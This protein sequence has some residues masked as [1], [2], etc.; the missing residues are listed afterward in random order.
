MPPPCHSVKDVDFD[1]CFLFFIMVSAAGYGRILD[2][3]TPKSNQ[4]KQTMAAN[5]K[6]NKRM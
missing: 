4:H 6:A 1:S 3:D 5:A 2:F